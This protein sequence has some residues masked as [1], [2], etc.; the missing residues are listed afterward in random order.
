MKTSDDL[1]Q[2]LLQINHKSYPAY[3]D[4]RGIYSFPGYLL[5]IDHVQGDP[6]AAP[7]KVS[8]HVN[9]QIAGFPSFLYHTK[10]TRIAL[11][12]FLIR[13]FHQKIE[14]FTFKAKG[15]GKSGLISI[16]RCQQEVLE[17]SACSVDPESGS[18]ILR[19]EVGFPANGRSI[20]SPELIKIFFDFLPVCVRGSLY[21][22]NLDAKRLEAVCHLAEDQTFIRSQLPLLGLTA[23]VANGSVLP[24]ES[25]VSPR[26]MKNGIP[27][28]APP[29]MEVTL[30]LPHHGPITGMGIAKGITLIVGGGYHGKSTLL[31]AL[32]LGVYD[33]I[34]GDGRE[35]VITQSDA[36]KIRAEDGRSI[37]HTDISLFINDLPNG[38]DTS[39]FYSDDASGSTS[40]AANVIE[41]LEAHSKLLLIDEDTSATNFMIRD[42]LMQRVVHKDQEPITPFIERVQ[43]LSE[44]KEISTILV[45]GSSGS[46]F[47]VA[48]K[49]VQM[50]RYR[51]IDITDFA[52]KEAMAFP[53]IVP[54]IPEADSADHNR[55]IK[56]DAD[57]REDRRLKIKPLGIDGISINRQNIDLRYVEQL[58]DPEQVNALALIL[59]YMQLHLF[60]GKLTLQDAVSKLEAQLST[61]GFSLISDSNRIP[62]NLAMPRL[63]EVFACINRFRDLKL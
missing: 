56:P 30:D 37:K 15:S 39:S 12:D 28:Q 63:Q 59:R 60:D 57:F 24:R 5:S 53:S 54:S 2:H 6:F 25:G 38:K 44:K 42:E 43:Y 19:M 58:T 23:F 52:K 7:S 48:D 34:S 51:P 50:D 26:P 11:Q 49:I 36:F 9:G 47:H 33:H 55:L 21:Y 27:F 45:A 4:T 14:R 35:Y 62:P 40:Q 46:Y 29:S 32:E 18:L 20:N 22:K 17:R 10:E 16:T 41:A 3:K 13:Q 8:I 1:K 61:Q 31:S